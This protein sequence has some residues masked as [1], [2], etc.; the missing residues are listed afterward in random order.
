MYEIGLQQG[1]FGDF[2]IDVTG[3]YRDVRNWISTSPL[4]ITYNRVTYSMYINKDYANVKGITLVLKKRYSQ[5]YSFD[6]SY[7]FQVAEGSNSSPE[8]EFNAIR[9]NLEPTLYLLPLDWDQRHLINGSFYVG[10]ETWGA[11][12]IARFGTGLPYTPQ[13]T[14]YTADRGI[15]WGLQKNS[16]RKPNQFSMD[17][18]LHKSFKV[19]GFKFTAFTNIY[20]LLDN[21][22]PI[23]VFADTGKPDYTT[24]K[25]PDDFTKRPN[26][27]AEYRK[28][29]WHYAEPRRVL[30]GIN[31]NF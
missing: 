29:P 20:N 5:N 15:H 23:N 18:R 9:S 3:F 13:I 22:I 7:T 2:K 8:D 17:L 28:Y 14:Q 25:T 12:L 21:H 30:F 19:G 31:Y 1:L 6:I 16:R 24:D 27:V 4:Y 26:T 10:A 11:S